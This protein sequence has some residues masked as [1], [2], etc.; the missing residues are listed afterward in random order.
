MTKKLTEKKRQTLLVA[1]QKKITKTRVI[2]VKT[3]EYD[4]YIG[5]TSK[6]GN[7]FLIGPNGTREE[8]IEKYRKSIYR[9]KILLLCIP[10][11]EGKRLGCFCPPL[12]CHGDVL[13]ELIEN[14]LIN[15]EIGVKKWVKNI[16]NSN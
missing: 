8:V 9:N 5:R 11:L 6:W 10:K 2:N 13:V 12:A 7:Q 14:F 1:L 4:V 16:L 15:K 3:E